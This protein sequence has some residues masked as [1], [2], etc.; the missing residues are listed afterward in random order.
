MALYITTEN[1]CYSCDGRRKIYWL[2]LRS[3]RCLINRWLILQFGSPKIST[4]VGLKKLA[5]S[6]DVGSAGCL[7]NSSDLL[8]WETADLE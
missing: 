8:I 2:V 5:L 7:T 6:S 1:G 4:S 3:W